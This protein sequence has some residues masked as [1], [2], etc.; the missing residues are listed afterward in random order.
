[1]LTQ[2]DID[3]IERIVSQELEEKIK[4]LPTKNEFFTKMDQVMGELGA[5]R[6]EQTVISGYKNQLEDHESRITQLEETAPA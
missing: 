5:I 1:M 2:K 6:E 4:L 3:E